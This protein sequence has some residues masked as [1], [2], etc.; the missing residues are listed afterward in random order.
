MLRDLVNQLLGK[1]IVVSS[2]PGGGSSSFA[3][4]MA[5]TILENDK[6]VLYY[7][8]SADIDRNFVKK[9]Y[10][11]VFDQAIWLV[12][13]L[14][15]F[16]E[17]LQLSE[18]IFD[19]LIIDPGDTTMI[20]PEIIPAIGLQKSPESTLLVTSQIRQDPNKAWAPYSTIE[21]LNSF[22]YS[23]W[24]TNVTG[25]HPMYIQKYVDV[26]QEIRSGNNFKMRD[27]AFYTSEGN[28]IEAQ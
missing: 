25:K 7:N 27:I 14:E 9:Y 22:D 28:I 23:L 12:T 11:R 8:P 10:P 20:N 6:M 1:R 17:C 5:N 3:L 24:I 16:L 18:N 4:Y 26:Y 15:L 19:C 21:R 2:A 13:S